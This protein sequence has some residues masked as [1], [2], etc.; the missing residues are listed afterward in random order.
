[1]SNYSYAR[2]GESCQTSLA[3][4]TDNSKYFELNNPEYSLF[5][6]KM[7]RYPGST[8]NPIPTV[9]RVDKPEDIKTKEN[10]CCGKK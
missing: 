4:L 5:Y 3:V 9:G 2:L 8:H 6:T 7:Y 1:M 10:F